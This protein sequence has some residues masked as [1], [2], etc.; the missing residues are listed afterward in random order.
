MKKYYLDEIEDYSYINCF[1][2]IQ[3]A[4]TEDERGWFTY[5]KEE[6]E[7]WTTLAEALYNLNDKGVDVN[8]LEVNELQD[9]IDYYNNNF[10]S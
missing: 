7:W 9:Y 4:F 10:S 8:T 5:D 1:E 2:E 3:E 6:Y